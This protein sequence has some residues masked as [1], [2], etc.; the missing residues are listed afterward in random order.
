MVLKIRSATISDADEIAAVHVQSWREVYGHLL[1]PEYFTTERIAARQR[2]WRELLAAPDPAKVVVVALAGADLVGFAS[3]TPARED[4]TDHPLPP[5][6][7]L[8]HTLYLLSAH[9][10]TGV[11]Q[12]LL[13]AALAPGSA[14]LWVAKQNPR[15]IAFYQR[16][17]F[18]FD[19]VEETEPRFPPLLGARMVR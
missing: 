9:H 5:D 4:A 15:A 19:G 12:Q 11:G 10:G 16:N 1:G 2:M 18:M 7:T 3:S 13:D 6:T 8:L 17:G 14:V